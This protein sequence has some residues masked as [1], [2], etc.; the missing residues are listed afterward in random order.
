MNRIVIIGSS[1]AGHT[2]ALQLRAKKAQCAI[3]LVTEE[4]FPAY[5][6]RK[7]ARYFAGKAKDKEL[8][9]GAADAYAKEEIA[10]IKEA[11]VMAVNAERRTVSMKFDEKRDR[12]SVV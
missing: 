11:K 12:K 4:K 8:F 10:F 7:L 6:R 3:T 5:D 2:L 1:A 9:L